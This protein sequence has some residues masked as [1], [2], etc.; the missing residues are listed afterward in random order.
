[1]VG[2]AVYPAAVG[3]PGDQQPGSWATNGQAHDVQA[4]QTEYRYT[5]TV[6]TWPTI[7][8]RNRHRKL[9]RRQRLRHQVPGRYHRVVPPR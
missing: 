5:P 1:L 7:P 8:P 4:N 6:I 2:A 3:L 9:R